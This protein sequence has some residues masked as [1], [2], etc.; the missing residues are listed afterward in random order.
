M[1]RVRLAATFVAL[2]VVGV[3]VASAAG[4]APGHMAGERHNPCAFLAPDTPGELATTA[5]FL[6]SVIGIDPGPPAPTAVQIVP[7]EIG[8]TGPDFQDGVCTLNGA[9]GWYT[10]TVAPC[11]P[12]AAGDTCSPAYMSLTVVTAPIADAKTQLEAYQA[13]GYTVRTELLKTGGHGKLACD[14]Y[15]RCVAWFTKG[16][17]FVYVYSQNVELP[18][19]SAMTAAAQDIY[20]HTTLWS[21]ERPPRGAR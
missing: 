6:E 1:L 17:K 5:T 7:G 19:S 21:T 2:L 3:L 15:A 4:A 11:V 12:P 9:V 8:Y 10:G 20:A 18:D 13:Y 14:T 16:T